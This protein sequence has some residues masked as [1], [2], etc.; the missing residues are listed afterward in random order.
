[1]GGS[2]PLVLLTLASALWLFGHSQGNHPAAV[3]IQFH[4]SLLGIVGVGAAF[5][6]GLASW[7][8]GASPH[9]R[10]WWEIAWAGSVILFG[11]LLLVY[12][13]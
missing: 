4:H 2:T 5:S 9:T 10:K 11:L 12:S 6:K 8:P 13:E 7:L 1:M 3:K